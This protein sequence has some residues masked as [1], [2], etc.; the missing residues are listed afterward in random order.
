MCVP[1]VTHFEKRNMHH[2]DRYRG[3]FL[4]SHLSN[5]PISEPQML[6]PDQERLCTHTVV[7]RTISVLLSSVLKYCL[8]VSVLN[9][10]SFISDYFYIQRIFKIHAWKVT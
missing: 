9:L 1:Y 6:T 4:A 3:M 5:E 10:S 2:R 8:A 7:V